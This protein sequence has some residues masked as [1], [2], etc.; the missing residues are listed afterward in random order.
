MNRKIKFS[1]KNTVDAKKMLYERAIFY[2]HKKRMLFKNKC[3]ENSLKREW[4]IVESC[5][6]FVETKWNED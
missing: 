4:K 3:I 1:N 2:I 6:G 5:R